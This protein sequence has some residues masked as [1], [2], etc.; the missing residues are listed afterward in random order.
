MGLH[1]I[2]GS[3]I[4]PDIIG[5]LAGHVYIFLEH[6]LPRMKGYRVLKT[7][8][9]LYQ[10]I[11]PQ[12][13]HIRGFGVEGNAAQQQQQQQQQQNQNLRQRGGYNWGGQGRAL[14]RDDR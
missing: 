1:L 8:G 4:I 14:G 13:V 9:F 10:L 5:I 3:S 7:P 12:R 2:L 6:D 11:P